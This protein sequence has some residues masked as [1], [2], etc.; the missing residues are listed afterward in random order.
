MMKVWGVTDTGLV[1]KQNQDAYGVDMNR[2]R[3]KNGNKS[4]NKE[5]VFTK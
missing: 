2:R 1:R 5:D 3:S 4:R